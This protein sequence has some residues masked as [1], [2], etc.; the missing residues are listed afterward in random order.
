MGPILSTSVKFGL[1]CLLWFYFLLF[2]PFC[3]HW[4]TLVLLRLFSPLWSYSVHFFYFG[5]I[6]SILFTF[7]LFSSYW[8]YSIQ[9]V[10]FGPLW[11]NFVPFGPFFPLWSIHSYS[12]HSDL[13]NPPCSYLVLFYSF[14]PLYSIWSICVKHLQWVIKLLG[15]PTLK[16]PKNKKRKRSNDWMKA[17]LL[18]E[19]ARNLSLLRPYFVGLECCFFLSALFVSL[20]FVILKMH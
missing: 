1:F 16:I 14:G 20:T 7:I 18:E 13:F 3:S 12:I 19:Y 9:S 4:S 8:S 10:H 17:C 11:S 5:S 6:R 15:M 2:S